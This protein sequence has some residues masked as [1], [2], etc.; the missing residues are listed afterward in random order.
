MIVDGRM[1]APEETHHQLK[2]RRERERL[3]EPLGKPWVPLQ[4]TIKIKT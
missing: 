3:G 4:G 2:Q 1:P